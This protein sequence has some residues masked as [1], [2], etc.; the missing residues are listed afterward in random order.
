RGYLGRPDLTAERF[1][2]DPWSESAGARLYRTGDR[3]RMRQDG[4]LDYLG[5]RDGQIKLRGLRIE[6]GEVEAALAAHPAVKEAVA[7]THREGGEAQLIGYV[8]PRDGQQLD[9]RAVQAFL[10]ERLPGALVPAEILTLEALPRTASGKLDRRALPAPMRGPAH[11]VGRGPRTEAERLLA[12]IWAEVLDVR[13]IGIDDN[14]FD[15]GGHSLL[16]V[17]IASRIR[18]TF[19]VDVPLRTLFETPTVA[20]LA[21]WL[22]TAPSASVAPAS[23]PVAAHEEQ[24]LQQLDDLSPEALEALLQE[25]G[26]SK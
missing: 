24:L 3:V 14:F 26:E 18:N 19:A 4:A 9:A 8:V 16:A 22:A 20:G 11:E 13:T 1:L 15:L 2:P 7:T 6:L 12:E 17:Q 25:Y 5:R 23:I 21:A 10:R